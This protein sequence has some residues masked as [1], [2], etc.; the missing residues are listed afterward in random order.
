MHT[1]KGLSHY[2]NNKRSAHRKGQANA[3]DK[4]QHK[5]LIVFQRSHNQ[6]V[7]DARTKFFLENSILNKEKL[8]AHFKSGFLNK[9]YNHS[10]HIGM[11]LQSIVEEPYLAEISVGDY[12]LLEL[13]QV[14]MFGE[15][16][17]I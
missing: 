10:K 1:S 9:D 3:A 7:L 12:N 17:F 5:T 14:L 2:N 15:E 6:E 13:L 16:V 8:I 11:V 4:K